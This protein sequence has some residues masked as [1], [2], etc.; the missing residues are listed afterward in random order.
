MQ[1]ECLQDKITIKTA[2][3]NDLPEVFKIVD[4]Y[5]DGKEIDPTK[6]KNS[7]RD[8]IYI[9]GAFYGEY[10]GKIIGGVA[11]YCLPCMF[12][13]DVFFVVMFLYIKNEYRSLTKSFMQELEMAFLPT[14]VN[15]IVIAVMNDQNQ[16]VQKRFL[17]M[18]GYKELETHMIKTL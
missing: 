12:N 8:L 2:Q 7:L 15:K 10:Q 9:Q 13:D 5:C 4:G 17:T 18:A 14:K 16:R 3:P 6:V 1:K 11:G